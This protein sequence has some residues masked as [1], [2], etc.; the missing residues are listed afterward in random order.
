MQKLNKKQIREAFEK[1]IKEILMERILGQ[2]E[3]FTDYTPEEK[4]RNFEYLRT[5]NGRTPEERNPS[6]AAALKA[7][8][9]RMAKK[10]AGLTEKRKDGMPDKANDAILRQVSSIEEEN[11]SGIHIDPKNKG[12]F[13]KTKQET[14]KTTSELLKS[15]NPKTAQRANFAR[16]AKRHFKP[17]KE[18]QDKTSD[19]DISKQWK[20]RHQAF[21][22]LRSMGYTDIMGDRN[23][24]RILTM[25]VD[26]PSDRDRIFRVLS[27]WLGV[28]NNH[29]MAVVVVPDRSN[30]SYV[31]KINLP[32]WTHTY[33]AREK[34][35]N[36]SML[37]SIVSESIRNVLMEAHLKV[38]DNIEDIKEYV[39][40]TWK[41]PN[42]IWWIEIDSR[43][44]DHINY[45]KRNAGDG[46]KKWWNRVKGPDGLQNKNIAGYA[47]VRGRTAEDAAKSIDNMIVHLNPWAEKDAGSKELYSNGGCEAIKTACRMF[48][49]RAY[50][51]VNQRDI[52]STVDRARQDR[53]QGLFKGREF[54]HR[55]G[56]IKTGTDS[57][58]FNWTVDRPNG[59]VDCDIDNA[60]AQAW[61]DNYFKQQGV[62]VQF[63][64]PSHD[65][66]H[67]VISIEDAKKC[68]FDYI[69]RSLRKYDTNNVKGDPP[70]L[71]K[72]DARLILYSAVG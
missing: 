66:M 17:L 45:N 24:L 54:H 41:S 63:R 29:E 60:Q 59:V 37:R 22:A 13:T 56:Q 55:A 27:K 43:K 49:A 14:G 16:M 3:S 34:R 18:E 26:G 50:I 10:K 21:T 71:F 1:T 70:V 20:V 15:K 48:F 42:D 62:T 12:K 39:R 28:D 7:A 2:G 4:E 23:D 5:G 47:I 57:S 65:G 30:T 31:C 11:K 53:K 44:K 19:N 36:E 6:Y 8:Q 69:L 33:I 64:K 38:V 72:P 58:G 52:L 9:E 40:L 35:I 32:E 25:K 61:L 68:D 67:Y 51:T 46:K